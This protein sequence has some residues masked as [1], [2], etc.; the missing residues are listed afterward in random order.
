MKQLNLQKLQNALRKKF[1]LV[2]VKMIGPETIFFSKDTKI[3]K[4]VIIDCLLYTSPSP[5]DTRSSRMPSSA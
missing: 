5:R 3:G 1:L 4:N 2:G